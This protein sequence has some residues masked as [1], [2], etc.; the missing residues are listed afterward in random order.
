MN[1]LVSKLRLQIEEKKSEGLDATR[2]LNGLKEYLQ[3]V[4]LHFIYNS[5][6]YS[7]L[8]MYGGSLLRI[9]HGLKRMSEDLDFQTED[10]VDLNLLKQDL[11]HY[12]QN[13][14]DFD[15]DVKVKTDRLGGTNMLVLGFNIL[16]ELSLETAYKTLKIRL[17]INHLPT[18]NEFPIELI[19][20]VK[21]DYV[22]SIKTYTL[23]VLMA[24]KIAAVFLRKNRSVGTAALGCKP[25]DLYDLLWYMEKKVVPDLSYLKTKG[26]DYKNVLEVFTDLELRMNA[27]DDKDFALDLKQFF[28]TDTAFEQWHTTWRNTF[29]TLLKN[30]EIFE[31]G[32]LDS[33]DLYTDFS[34]DNKHFCFTFTTDV[35]GKLVTFFFNLSEYWFVDTDVRIEKLYR[36]KSIEGKI[37]HTENKAISDYDYEYIGLFYTKII[38]YL[39]RNDSIV[40]QK[41]LKTRFIRATGDH[42]DIKKQIFLSRRMLPKVKLEE[43]L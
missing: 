31:V 34:T 43:L 12:F 36:V 42:L 38:D 28:Y 19:P 25:R 11:I 23:P 8:T 32:G 4:I 29:M 6:E 3:F 1:Y 13:T 41:E 39:K 10:T 24:S 33:I 7:R 27:I 9:C 16:E 2:L 5:K 14:Y 22:F 37:Q 17:D 40:L 15:L 20:I 26:C 21:D 30:Y 18:T 35:P